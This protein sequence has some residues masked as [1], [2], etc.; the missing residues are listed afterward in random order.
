M[1][2]YLRED[3]RW[4]VYTDSLSP[5]LVIENKRE[6]H[7]ILNQMYNTLAE[8]H[9]QGKQITICKVSAHIRI[10]GNKEADRAAKQATD[11]PGMSK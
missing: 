4:V 7:P 6:N 8:L 5:M 10:K 9:N 2:I 3:M 1:G 11:I